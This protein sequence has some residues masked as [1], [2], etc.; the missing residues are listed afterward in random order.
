MKKNTFAP[1][2]SVNAAV[3]VYFALIALSTVAAGF[4]QGLKAAY[5]IAAGSGITL[6]W[7]CIGTAAFPAKS[8]A[9][10]P[11]LDVHIFAQFALVALG[12]LLDMHGGHHLLAVAT[13]IF[14]LFSL[15]LVA[16]SISFREVATLPFLRREFK[17]I[18]QES[19]SR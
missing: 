4:S 3:A 15:V 13:L 5:I 9:E 10:E 12:C 6:F 17:R 1:Y 2:F 7:V 14:F 16:F 19:N 18:A 8:E 11:F